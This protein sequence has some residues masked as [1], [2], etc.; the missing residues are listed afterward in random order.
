MNP[1]IV[2]RLRNVMADR[3]MF[4]T[5]DLVEPLQNAGVGLSREQIFRLVTQQPKRLNVDVLAALCSILECTPDDLLALE[6][7][8]VDDVRT[9]TSG[10]ATEPLGPTRP[11][12]ARIRRPA[13]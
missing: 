11:V 8:S 5:S 1:Q 9:G 7:V 13:P 6:A 12:A 4:K 10:R 2:W 3:G